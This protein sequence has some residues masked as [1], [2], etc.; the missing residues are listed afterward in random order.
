MISYT[1]YGVKSLFEWIKMKETNILLHDGQILK[2]KKYIYKYKTRKL[3][4][5][6]TIG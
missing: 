2:P 3:C 6:K 1:L 4:T 5:L